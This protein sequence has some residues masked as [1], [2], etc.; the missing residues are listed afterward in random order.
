M[1]LTVCGD[2]SLFESWVRDV[3]LDHGEGLN[4]SSSVSLFPYMLGMNFTSVTFTVMWFLCDLGT[5]V[6]LMFPV[7]FTGY[8]DLIMWCAY[9]KHIHLI[10]CTHD[11]CSHTKL[12]YRFCCYLLYSLLRIITML[13]YYS[14][15]ICYISL[16]FEM[17]LC[18]VLASFFNLM[19]F[20]WSHHSSVTLP[21]G[22]ALYC[23]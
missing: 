15:V 19:W 12:F 10:C 4:I 13:I 5:F 21:S 17:Q 23:G 11:L 3:V 20:F 9:H 8:F 16:A 2:H 6:L 14:A 1:S 18:A 22:A 7:S